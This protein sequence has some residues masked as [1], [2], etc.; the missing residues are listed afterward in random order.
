[1]INKNIKEKGITLVALVI[2]IIILLILAGITIASIVGENGIMARSQRAKEEH[3][4]SELMEKLNLEIMAVQTENKGIVTIDTFIERIIEKNIIDESDIE[5]A[6]NAN[7][8]YITIEEYVFLVENSENKNINIIYQGKSGSLQPKIQNIIVQTTSNSITVKVE[9]KRATEGYEYYIKES[10]D[11]T[12]EKIDTNN[13]AQYTFEGLEQGKQYDIKVIAKNKSGEDAVEKIFIKTQEIPDLTE[14]N[15]SFKFEPEGWTNEDVKVTVETKTTGYQMQLSS[16][17][18]GPWETKN[19]KTFTENGTIYVRLWDGKN[20]G[21]YASRQITKIDKI[22]PEMISI[23]NSAVE[24][25]G[26]TGTVKI[27]AKAKDID[28][29]IDA[30]QFSTD[31]NLIESSDGWQSINATINEITITKD[32]T[33][34]G[35]WYFY[36]KDQAGNVNKNSI[37]VTISDITSPTIEITAST[38]EWINGDVTLTGKSKD[39][40][41]GIVAYTWTTSAATPTSWDNITQTTSEITQTIKLTSNGTRYFW[42]KDGNGNINSASYTVNIIDK[43]GPDKPTIYNPTGEKWTN[44]QFSLTLYSTDNSGSGIS[45]YQYSYDGSEWVTY[46]NSSTADGGGFVTTPFHVERNQLVYI[47]AC[48]KVGNYSEVASTMIKISFSYNVEEGTY[49]IL[50][51]ADSSKCLDVASFGTTDKTNIFLWTKNGMGNQAFK[52][53]YLGDGYYKIETFAEGK[54]LDV[55]D[56]NSASG[57]N[58]QQYGWNDSPAQ[59]W[60]FHRRD[61]G[62]YFIQSQLGT[63]ID[64]QDGNTSDG[65]NVQLWEMAGGTSQWWYL[66]KVN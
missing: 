4:I 39:T 62:W 32:I 7:S 46:G 54:V 30:Y 13:T 2:T 9:A 1:M 24:W 44:T 22:K 61:E 57:T 19:Q 38:T 50:S 31:E 16:S 47:R 12:Y 8:K 48:D 35:T 11:D 36:V 21:N 14:E 51:S 26:S 34:G 49:N 64:L 15:I 40:E 10:N 20:E 63:V 41:S 28:S 27:T 43:D 17:L 56:G 60:K 18:S 59:K 33:T 66:N 65:A 3:K 52:I 58:L 53:V 6:E 55:T 25:S 42:T 23:S 29:G 37:V 5:N 45:F